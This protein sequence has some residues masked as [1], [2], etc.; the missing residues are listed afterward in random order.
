MQVSVPNCLVS[1]SGRKFHVLLNQTLYAELGIRTG[2][3]LG[4]G[5]SEKMAH[6]EFGVRVS[7]LSG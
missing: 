3:K 7:I 4:S 6:V 5:I 2:A 1:L